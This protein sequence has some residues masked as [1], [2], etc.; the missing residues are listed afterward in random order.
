MQRKLILLWACAAVLTAAAWL[1]HSC[2]HNGDVS[3]LTRHAPADWILYPKPPV[4]HLQGIAELPAAFQ[5]SFVV[6]QGQRTATLSLRACRRC[7]VSINGQSVALPET[8]GNWKQAR[9]VE[10]GRFLEAGENTLRVTVFNR[11]GPPALWLMLRGTGV[12][13]NSD[14]SWE[15]SYA[16]AVWQPAHLAT[17]PLPV[18]P[19]TPAGGGETTLGSVGRAWKGLMVLLA[20]SAGVL[21]LW[22]WWHE[23]ESTRML[24]ARWRWTSDPASVLLAVIAMSWIFLW[25]HNVSFV[26]RNAGFDTD[27]HLE[28]I[29]YIQAHRALPLADQGW[30]MH[31]PPLYYVLCAGLLNGFGLAADSFDGL[32]MLRL[33]GLLI[34]LVHLGIVFASVRLLFPGE[35]AQQ[36]VGLSLA[37]FLPMHL[38]LSHYV[39]N[40]TLAACLIS[41]TLLY[42]LRLL[43][44][45]Q[46]SL[47][48]YAAAG[49]FLGLA[50]LTKVTAVVLAPFALAALLYPALR[51]GSSGTRSRVRKAIY[52]LAGVGLCLAVCGWHYGRVWRH[53]G[54]VLFAETR[55]GFGIGWWQDPGYR[56]AAY[57]A[58]FGRSLFEPFFSGLA[59]FGDGL[60]STLWGDGLCGGE[61]SLML[62]P[63][64]NYDLMTSGFLLALGPTALI[65]AGLGVAAAR[66]FRKPEIRWVLLLFFAFMMLL[67]L[68]HLNLGVPG[69]A[70]AKS[71]YGLCA[72]VPICAL[73]AAGW[74]VLVRNGK[75]V[76]V[77][78]SAALTLW[79]M[80]SY[81][82]FW[83]RGNS[84][85]TQ[86][87]LGRGYRNAGQYPAALA[88][89]TAALEAEPRHSA[90]TIY[91]VGTLLKQER[92]TE[93]EALAHRAVR[94]HP[95]NAQCHFVLASVLEGQGQLAAAI[96][97]TRRA[98]ELAPD[99]PNAR[100]QLETRLFQAGRFG[101]AIL[102]GRQALRLSA[103]DPDVHAT[104]AC[105][106]L[107]QSQIE[108]RG[109]GSPRA[110]V[111]TSGGGKGESTLPDSA[112]QPEATTALE[113]TAL[114]GGE[115]LA[116]GL[117]NLAA[118]DRLAAEAVNHFRFAL[119]LAPDSPEVLRN[120]AWILATHPRAELRNGKEAIARAERACV[121]TGF[122]EAKML[123][124]L[125]AAQAEAGDF[126][127]AEGTAKKALKLAEAPGQSQLRESTLRMLDSFQNQ[128]PI[129][130]ESEALKH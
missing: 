97:S 105:A 52:A 96:E 67:A 112:A 44:A 11:V 118:G 121:L 84:A 124:T 69:Y 12:E 37:G 53:F 24:P 27:G 40:E 17:Q 22:R 87:I 72:L 23:R 19:G 95:D 45:E 115:P 88:H 62:R 39:T 116:P 108:G 18:G 3:F 47:K 32:A 123:G 21:A 9:T 20:L 106:L 73:A 49:I 74:P 50:L 48:S 76:R 99:E 85:D 90:A 78:A 15:V 7:E 68:I 130:Q 61:A 36:V 65:L 59:S 71:F 2:E 107:A 57:F 86:A 14:A 26:P 46:A 92:V 109:Q 100:F 25:A 103:T 31:Q 104:L 33:L 98:V 93:A 75:P 4:L 79:A 8:S 63:P 127:A 41:A 128:R 77:L 94:E 60:Y 64:W 81:A 6:P 54:H 83:I 120:L 101:D 126:T 55:F 35:A 38:Y 16:G 114:A 66:Y 125:A 129:R 42:L 34:G 30:E 91:L 89:L 117:E 5:R 111:A 29:K 10:V 28:Y 58:H 122:G 43:G 102:A 119:E 13:L 70:E 110:P 1:W 56:T 51:G 113:P 82:S 80:T